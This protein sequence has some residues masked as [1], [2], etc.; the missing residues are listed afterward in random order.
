MMN[1]WKE[2]LR[3]HW[4]NVRGQKLSRRFLV[5]ESD[6]WGS[7]R[8]PDRTSYK[9][10]LKGGLRVDA[11]PYLRY[12]TL[13][14]EEDLEALFE[15]LASFRDHRHQHPV[16][17]ANCVLA[18]PDFEA[19]RANGFQHYHFESMTKTLAAYPGREGAFALW[20]QGRREG[21][22]QPQF[23]GRE[24]L[25]VARWMR[26][27][28][29][30]L[31][32]VRQAFDLRLFG[33]SR[34]VCKE[35]PNSLLEAWAVDRPEDEAVVNQSITEGL[36][37]FHQVFGEPAQ[38]MIAPNYCWSPRHEELAAAAGVRFIQGQRRQL[39]AI[40]GEPALTH[41]QGQ[42]NALGQ[43]YLVRNAYF[44]PSL[45]PHS[46][47]VA[48]CLARISAAF[49]WNRPAV[50]G[51]HRLNFIGALDEENRRRNLRQ[52]RALLH[53]VLKRWPDVEFVT[54]DELGRCM[55]HHAAFLTA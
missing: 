53:A 23:H 8:M 45:Y 13:A 38:S 34:T 6:D 43:V 36:Q 51:V 14:T 41:H 42:R 52:L 16:L 10:L 9:A 40:A 48:T 32:V 18:N 37:M 2:G 12:D 22:F 47:A 29:G 5:L 3:R 25:N 55:T 28:Q 30:G 46:D 54:S 35:L 20:N 7:V 24:H 27:L 26:A 1:N 17:T 33:I 39:P 11:C 50:V 44:E 31:P 21:L 15:V 49:A 4:V 19:I